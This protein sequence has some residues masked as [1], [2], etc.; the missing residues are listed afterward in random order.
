MLA[1]E[2]HPAS[3]VARRALRGYVYSGFFIDI[4]VPDSLAAA[5]ELVPRPPPPARRSSSTA[6][7][8]STS[9]A[10]MSMR[11]DR[12]SGS[13]APEQ[14]VK[15]LNDAG[16]YVFVV[17]NQ[18]GVA[19]GL[20]ARGR[21]SHRLHRWMAEELAAV[22]A[23]ID[24]WRYCPYH[25]EGSVEAYRAA[26]R[27]AEAEPGHDPRPFRS[28]ADRAGRE[29]SRR[30][31]GAAT[32]RPRRP[33]ACPAICSRAAT[34]LR[35]H[36]SAVASGG[37]GVQL[38]M[39]AEE[40]VPMSRP[41]EDPAPRPTATL[42]SEWRRTRGV[43][44]R[45][46]ADLLA[47]RAR[48]R[49]AALSG[50]DVDHGREGSLPAPAL[51]AGPP[52]L[53]LLRTRPA[54]LGRRRGG[55]W[56]RRTSIFLSRAGGAPTGSTSTASIPRAM[57][58]DARADL[59]DQAFMLLALAHAGRALGRPDLFAVAEA[60]DDALERTGAC[61]TAA[62]TRARSRSARRTGRTRTCICSR[63]S[64]RWTMRAATAR[65]RRDAEHVARLCA[66]SFLHPETGAL[67]EY[68]DA[69][70]RSGRGRGGPDRRA[71][72]LLRMG[73]AVRAPG[74]NGTF[75]TRPH[76]RRHGALRPPPRARRP[77]GAS[78]S[79]RS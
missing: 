57:C 41:D 26:H 33:R 53:L 66:R 62:I 44:V 16:Y 43:A 22:G 72:P 47:R 19:K 25:P 77:S 36:A 74:G 78:R 1:R 30:R 34:S 39:T 20:Y 13:K 79:T 56:S 4:G 18:A 58:F 71:R 9:T 7:A 21:R 46:A 45:A 50:A 75:R 11:P 12:S 3:L 60:L 40:T 68:F 23:S 24:D 38:R 35:V 5:A 52:C 73:V 42:S 28:L 51:R 59:Y 14:A 15:R 27:L 61:P 65:W 49:D 8:C 17:T 54:R 32:S 6:T 48:R 2:R 31:Q 76:L 67:L 29:L 63:A 10:A 70:P 64:S 55:R 69:E 37:A